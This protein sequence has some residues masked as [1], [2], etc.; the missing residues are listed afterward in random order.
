MKE[1]F[2]DERHLK[3]LED[4]DL[5]AKYCNTNGDIDKDLILMG[6]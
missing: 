4:K 5:I 6:L 1:F 2:T 3:I